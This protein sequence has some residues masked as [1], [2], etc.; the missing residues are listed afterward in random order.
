[1]RRQATAARRPPRD[2]IVNLPE[3]EEVAKQVLPPE[4]YSAIAGG[5]R[6]AF[7]RITFRPRMLVPTVDLDLSVE[8][9]GDRH[10][11]PILVGPVAEQRRY[12]ADGELATVRGASAARAAVIIS[13]RSSVPIGEIAAEART[14]LWYSV[15]AD[16]DATTRKQVQQAVASGCKVLCITAGARLDGTR[17]SRSR[18]DWRAIEQIRRSVDVPIVIKGV[19]T[20]ADANAAIQQGARGII[21][22]DHGGA[23]RGTA[24]PI[25]ILPS[26]ADSVQGR[27]TVLVDGSFRR[28]TD[29]LKA[30]VL[31]AAGVVI[32]RPVMWGLASYGAEGVQSVIELAQTALGRNMSMIGAPNLKSLTRSMVKIHAR[33]SAT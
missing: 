9:F 32:A 27:A 4:A 18:V 26:I 17:A 5:D 11:A 23:A 29:L 1:M 24:S 12:H 7:D 30:L 14:P 19:M 8:L 2:E 21:V 20:T 25:E 22:S 15:Y 16:A 10:I 13:S 31:G 33:R 6:E 3:F 28:G